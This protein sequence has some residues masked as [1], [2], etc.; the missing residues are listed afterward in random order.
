M[1]VCEGGFQVKGQ[2]HMV[3]WNGLDNTA[4]FPSNLA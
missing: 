4:A 1:F 3:Y 2:E